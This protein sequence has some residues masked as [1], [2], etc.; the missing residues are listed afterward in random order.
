MELSTEKQSKEYRIM[1]GDLYLINYKIVGEIVRMELSSDI[2]LT[3][4]YD[5]DEADDIC[6]TL[7]P[8]MKN[9]VVR[10]LVVE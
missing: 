3:E 2:K 6:H 5:E 9:V 4:I 10:A 8:S 7:S 1:F